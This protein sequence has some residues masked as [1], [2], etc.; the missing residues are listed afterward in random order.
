MKRTAIV[1]IMIAGC[2]AASGLVWAKVAPTETPEYKPVQ[3]AAPANPLQYRLSQQGLTIQQRASAPV[4]G[5]V[6][7]EPLPRK[8]ENGNAMESVGPNGRC[9]QDAVGNA[10]NEITIGASPLNT[11]NVLSGSNDY[12]VGDSQGGFY[13][14]TDGGSTWS[15]ALVTRGPAG[16]FDAA[17]DPVAC[18]D[19][20]GRMFATYIGFDRNTPDNGIYV[21]TS[22]NNGTSWTGPVPVV[23]H[24]GGG[25]SDFEDKPYAC[26]DYSPSSPFI[27]NYYVS[28]TRFFAG[29][30]DRIYLARSTNGGTSFA[31]PVAVSTSTNVQFSCPTVGPAGQVYVVWC[32]FNTNTIQ[33]DR[34]TNGGV[35]FGADITVSGFTDLP[36]SPPC[37]TWRSSTIPSIACDISGGPRN[38]WLY[39]SWSDARNGTPDIYFSRSTDGGTT[40]SAAQRIDNSSSGWQF[41]SWIASNPT[42]GDLGVAWLDSREDASGCQYKEYGT[43]SNDGGVTWIPNFPISTVASNPSGSNFIGDY[44]GATFRSDGFY[45][46][47]TDLR[48]DAGDCYAASFNCTAP[49]N[50]A[51]PGYGISSLPYTHNGNTSCAA[52]DFS[53][54]CLFGTAPD[55]LYYYTPS[56]STLVTASTCGSSF[57]TGLYVRT[58]GACPGTTEVACNDDAGS[59]V[60]PGNVL[61]SQVTFTAI[62]GQTYYFIVDGYNVNSGPYTFNVTGTVLTPAPAND[63]CPGTAINTLPYSGSGSTCSA[64]ANYT[65]CVTASSP[66]VMYSLYLTSCQTVTISLCGSNFDTQ[67]GVYAGGS[68]PGTTLVACNDDY[69]GLQSQVTF[70]ADAYTYYYVMIGGFFG[71]TGNYVINVTGTPYVAPNDQCPGTTI[72][73]LPFS[74]AGSTYCAAHDYSV[75]CR[76]TNSPDVVYNYTPASCQ[77]VTATLCG[78]LYDVVIDVRAGGSCPGSVSVVCNDDNLCN[79][80]STLQSTVTFNAYAGVTYYMIVSGFNGAAGPF[81]FNVTNGGAFVPANDV[82]PGT[83]IA[84][85][86]FTDIGSTNCDA[87]NYPNFQGN[88][89][90]DAVYNYTSATCQS[91]TVTLCGSSYDTGLSVYRTG[92]CPGTVLVAGNDDNL[93]GGTSTL[94]STL[95]FQASAGVPYFILVHGFSS[96]YGP[97]VLNVTGQPCGAPAILDS[98]VILPI[99]AHIMLHWASQGPTYFYNI[100]RGTSPTGLVAPANKIDST[101]G[102]TYYDIGILS[103]PAMQYFYAVT[104]AQLPTLLDDGGNN[105]GVTVDKATAAAT[106]DSWFAADP[107]PA[108]AAVP[109]IDKSKAAPASE[110]FIPVYTSVNS[111]YVPNPDKK[112]Q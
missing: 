107:F 36:A 7:Y 18:V 92:A 78:T 13:R 62:P 44:C 46:G 1:S 90:P 11:N 76:I 41:F 50:D 10:Q 25:T 56:C 87:H 65:N 95:S 48:N 88:A 57:D 109:E 91:V 86:P 43:T 75:S 28:W 98:L 45:A 89:S 71:H 59:G 39:V 106:S 108:T 31:A 42:T 82:C 60:C 66:D 52:N 73:A 47:W 77:T 101:Q 81:V 111:H 21:H 3:V 63:A 69:C 40:W 104:A 38:G 110:D 17:G 23:Q 84:G 74:D 99:D 15:D 54:T 34:S 4:S 35:S 67:L 9:N 12:R 61:N 26:C 22:V 58:G 72:A 32:D 24:T 5:V 2:M 20:T 83:T 29:G 8:D 70:M 100:Y 19:A 51:C 16:V 14:T 37:G 80:V 79:G 85:L 112:A 53:G 55:V 102:T 96:D 97:Y 93:C 64:A 68:C 30:G 94:Q 27:N 6:L 103:S 49:G 105:A 33:F